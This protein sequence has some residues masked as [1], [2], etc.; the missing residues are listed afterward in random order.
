MTGNPWKSESQ[1]GYFGQALLEL[2]RSNPNVVVVGAD[3]TESLKTS[4]FG[5][6]FPERLFNIGIAEQ[7]MIGIAAGLA[8]SGKTAIAATYAVFGTAQVYSVIRQSVAY[9]KLNVKIFCSHAGTSVGPDGATHQMNEDIGLMRGLPNMVVLVPCDAPELARM[10]PATADWGGPTYCRFA[11]SDVPTITT[12]D[13]SFAIGKAS[14]IRDGP[15]ITLMGCG[16]MVAKCIEAAEALDD[17][18]IDARV[19][20]M[21]TIKPIDIDAIRKAAKDT[22][23]IVTAEEHSTLHGLG[24]AV[25]GEVARSRPVPME[26]VGMP[27]RFG[28]SGEGDQLLEKF[29]LTAAK[30]KDAAKK[31]E[32]LRGG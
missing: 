13:D 9:P 12:R 8:A 4:M 14:T 29:G 15:D 19:V 16:I 18:G 10:V 17:D 25:A 30:I 6:E 2:G 5:K 27:D 7:N 11:R 20:N 22:G 32:K 21:S 26:F 3:T 23:A 31:V 1:R 28:E 24:S